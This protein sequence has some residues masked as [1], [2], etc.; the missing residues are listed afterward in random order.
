M[1]VLDD[2]VLDRAAAVLDT[3]IGLKPELSMRPRLAR[4][5]GETA[6]ARRIPPAE[7]VAA[8]TSSA[9]LLDAVLDRITVQE[10]AFFRHPEQFAALASLLEPN[11][12]LHAW[13]AACANG[14]EA[15][16]LAM[17]IEERQRGG[18]VLATD[19]SPAA[20][21][22]TVA[23]RYEPREL[24]GLNESR[25]RQHFLRQHGQ[26]VVRPE[27]RRMVT[28]RRHNL[29]DPIPVEVTACRLVFCRNVLIYFAAAHAA[30]FLDRL[31][32]AMAMDALL[33]V[34]GA[35]MLW[36]VTDRFEPVPIAGGFAYRRTR[37]QVK[38]EP[39]PTGRAPVRHAAIDRPT[40]ASRAS[41]APRTPTSPRST[42]PVPVATETASMSD[43]SLIASSSAVVE[44]ERRLR[45]GDVAGAVVVYR[46]WAYESPDDPRAHFHLA[47]A[48]AAAADHVASTR[49]YR[50]ARGALDRCDPHQLDLAL[51][52]Y[53][54]GEFRRLV[55]SRAEH[56]TDLT[57]DLCGS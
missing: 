9:V 14:Q 48:L 43:A 6:V 42:P 20:I 35:E 16:T 47:V 28:I 38:V 39:K 19:I 1:S 40:R 31:A 4:A 27:L 44:G 34:G 15:Y 33:F 37:R 24:G 49:A 11:E 21:A 52:G 2:D 45:T 22:R 10:T 17:M 26:H 5:I 50:S 30:R 18:S 13:S 57:G 32:D 56:V 36:Q 53:D 12:P 25:R 8:M 29:L 46:Q 54:V 51:E 23:A 3:R 41:R 7:L 55:A